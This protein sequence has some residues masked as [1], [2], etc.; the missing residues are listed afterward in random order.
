M[1]NDEFERIKKNMSIDGV[2][3]E[4]QDSQ[5]KCCHENNSESVKEQTFC[6][7]VDGNSNEDQTLE[8]FRLVFRAAQKPDPDSRKLQVRLSW[9]L[10]GALCVQVIWALILISV[11][12]AQNSSIAA[13]ALTFITLL[14][15]AIL[16]EVV[17]MAFVVVRF[18]F[19]TPLDTMID[20]LK[21]IVNKQK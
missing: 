4:T 16:A 10:T 7:K 15:T 13:N 19:R 12:I 9:V 3:E 1:A 18:V 2:E 21:D 17:A 8:L 11:I 20:L 6:A 14:V 5:E